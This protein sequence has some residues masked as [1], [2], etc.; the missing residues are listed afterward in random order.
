ME[1]LI[2]NEDAEQVLK[3]LKKQLKSN[4]KAD[5]VRIAIQLIIDKHNLEIALKD[6]KD[7]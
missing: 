1:S 6:K 4:S 3:D 5:L 7:G 2:P